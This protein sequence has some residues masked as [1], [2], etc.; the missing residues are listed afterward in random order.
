MATVPTWWRLSPIRGSCEIRPATGG[1]PTSVVCD[2][3]SLASDAEATL[4]VTLLMFSN[5]S[6]DMTAH[7]VSAVED[8][9]AADNR[10]MLRVAAFELPPLMVTV[11]HE[12]EPPFLGAL[13][14]IVARAHSPVP[15]LDSPDARL[16]IDLPA[17]MRVLSASMGQQPCARGPGSFFHP[18]SSNEQHIFCGAELK[19]NGFIE[20]RIVAQMN[21]EV[22]QVEAFLLNA[23]S[24]P[25]DTSFSARG[26]HQI[27]VLRG[28]ASSTD[29]AIVKTGPATLVR[30]S[31]AEYTIVVTNVGASRASNVTVTDEAPS[32]IVLKSVSGACLQ[33]P[34]TF[35][36]L[37][38]GASRTIKAVFEVLV[39]AKGSIT[40]TAS[41][42]AD[43][44]SDPNPANDRSSI[45]STIG[46]TVP[47]APEI[48]AVASVAS[49]T[50][51]TVSWS[52]DGGAASY[53]VQEATT[54]TFSGA[55]T[56]R[57][58]ATT[59]SSTFKK[60]VTS[61][62]TFF[63]RVRAIAAC[64][65][66]DGAYSHVVEV[67]VQAPPPPV[68]TTVSLPTT[69]TPYGSKDPVQTTLKFPPTKTKSTFTAGADRTWVTVSPTSG[70]VPETGL[71]LRV[72]MDPASLPVGASFG[73]VN[74][75]FT[76]VSSASGIT[77]HETT[78][79]M[80]V[81]I[82]VSLVT[83]VTPSTRTFPPPAGTVVIPGVAHADGVGT[84]WRS[85]VRIANPSNRPVSYLL[86]YVS[87]QNDTNAEVKETTFAIDPGNTA[88][89]EDVVR[90]WF[91]TSGT[92][93][94]EIRPL[95]GTFKVVATSRTYNT[96]EG[97]TLGQ[98]VPAIAY[99]RFASRSSASISRLHLPQVA[100]SELYRTNVGLVEG[101]GS[102]VNTL[103][104][105]LGTDG[106]TLLE[107]PVLVRGGEHRQLNSLLHANGINAP[108]AR[109]EVSITGGSGKVTGYASVID[110]G[111]GDA[112]LVAPARLPAQATRLVLPGVGSLT[113]P[114]SRWRSDVHLFNSGTNT[115]TATFSYFTAGSSTAAKSMEVVLEPGST[116]AMN[117]VIGA[118]DMAGTMGVIHIT[119]SSA[120][121]LIASARTYDDQPDGTY[122]QF[123]SA[124]TSDDGV[125]VGEAA[126]QI[127]QAEES[128]H[129]R[130]NV[131]LF[132]VSGEPV[133]VE[134]TASVPGWKTSPVVELGLD[135]N[136][137][138]L[139]GSLLR[140]LNL[141]P[142]YN[143]RISIRAVGGTGRVAAFASS[144]DNHT[145]DPTY[146]PAQ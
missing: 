112:Q 142:A 90:T 136:E 119:S 87:T 18:N 14:T 89:L 95:E 24:D 22:A 79:V 104:R 98:F 130:T 41:V 56:Q 84:Q 5:I 60:D 132:E 73:T 123:I 118:L 63:Y 102:D 20:A 137:F 27:E 51:Y 12:P 113:T 34:C 101:S 92:G 140:Q 124:L 2:L 121:Q 19:A 9:D 62:T 66:S 129:S 141:E 3:G 74:V 15:Y 40:N 146:I 49:G 139:I 125:G 145:Q 39:K 97:G 58:A 46:C 28:T 43:R 16:V 71:I 131:G 65:G 115:A 93:M 88:A 7:A 109:V 45:T 117:D 120:A 57:L 31:E 133:R 128:V 76:P 114:T 108:D 116:R 83:P 135:A 54:S 1:A 13:V 52:A 69:I 99:G 75:T 143:A 144:V 21:V 44:N 80:S 30:G 100:Q 107:V 81:P 37:H 26:V 134:V 17:A 78:T 55:T 36:I 105:F 23:A 111:S 11:G 77:T 47:V 59:L 33:L 35:A 8:Q 70:V 94:L 10:A 122:G 25:I 38:P 127:L 72:T 68:S 138:I 126:L 48:N 82:S 86:T 96:T 32:G 110:N 29:L 91:G 67:R 50:G 4:D 103:V 85:D 106:N 42:I 53:E 6:A 64:D 61:D